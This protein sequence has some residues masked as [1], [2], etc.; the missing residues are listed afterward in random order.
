MDSVHH[1]VPTH[2]H[3]SVQPNPTCCCAQIQASSGAL[4]DLY[5]AA[6]KLYQSPQG[7]IM[8][9]M[10][11]GMGMPW[12]PVAGSESIAGMHPPQSTGCYS[13]HNHIYRM[14]CSAVSF[15]GTVR[16]RLYIFSLCIY[17][18]MYLP[19][20]TCY[21]V[22][23]YHISAHMLIER[24]GCSAVA[25]ESPYSSVTLLLLPLLPAAPAPPPSDAR[26]QCCPHGPTAARVYHY[27]WSDR[28]E[29]GTHPG[30]ALS[31]H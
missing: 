3:S 6:A 30:L 12:I 1:T 24:S 13:V 4:G 7:M 28:T 16:R 20:T 9:I 2:Y 11:M 14:N 21:A 23:S 10:G 15:V 5:Q 17:T 26:V 27:S 19:I 31:S 29:R 25:G 8:D 18:R 22:A